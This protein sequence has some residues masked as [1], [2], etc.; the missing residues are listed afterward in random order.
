MASSE[1]LSESIRLL[2]EI[3]SKPEWK[4]WCAQYSAYDV[5]DDFPELE[6]RINSF[7][8]EAYEQELVIQEYRSILEENG[9]SQCE[10]SAADDE[11]LGSLTHE[12]LT[13]AVAWHFRRDRFSEGSLIR[14]SIAE[15]AMLRMLKRL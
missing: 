9:I 2:E 3:D 8:R 7:I 1:F 5:S 4:L 11:W 14:Q 15:G 13:A 6:R 10:L 12:C